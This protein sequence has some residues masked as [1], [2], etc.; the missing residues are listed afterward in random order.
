MTKK[1]VGKI[2][3]F[4]DKISVAVLELS[5]S[6]KVGDTI[7]VVTRDGEFEQTVDSMQVEHQPVQ[8]A[9]KGDSVGMKVNE[10]VKEGDE[11]Y[12]V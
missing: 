6:L 1:P 8:T 11:V 12:L 3:H 4:F 10:K 5:G 7:K 2:K 9:K